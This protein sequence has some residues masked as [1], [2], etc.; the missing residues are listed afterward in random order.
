MAERGQTLVR[1]GADG[2]GIDLFPITNA[3][4]GHDL[5][6]ITRTGP[7]RFAIG[8]ETSA[9]AW[10]SQE[11]QAQGRI[12]FLEV[13]GHSARVTD[14]IALPFSIWGL[15]PQENQG[16]EGLCSTNG[17]L[18]AGIE[19]VKTRDGKRLAPLA[20]H[21]I[22]GGEWRPFY[23]Q[24]TSDEGK[25][26]S[27]ECRENGDGIEAL[28][29]ERHFGVMRV[30][31]FKVPDAPD[32]TATPEVVADFTSFVADDH[33]NIEGLAWLDTGIAMIIDNEYK[34][35]TGPNELLLASWRPAAP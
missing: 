9:E 29:V 32:A 25:L 18:I 35:V 22:G 6:S 16:I 14:Q 12:L 11:G 26:S 13:R 3:P 8:T 4:S 23:L 1:L 2:T 10:A 33:L 19:T 27:L 31:R 20:R 7:G 21:P 24:L 17:M 15:R 34:T 5:E 30:L 28:A